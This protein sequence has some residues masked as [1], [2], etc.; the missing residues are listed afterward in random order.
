RLTFLIAEGLPLWEFFRIWDGGLILYGSFAGGA[1]GYFGAYYFVLSKHGVSTWKLIDV[2]PPRVALGICLGPVRFPLNRCCSGIVACA[3]CA[4]V[5][6]PPSA[7]AR[8]HLVALGY[9]TAAGF[10]LDSRED[11]PVHVGAVEPD[12]PAERG[13]LRRGDRIVEVDGQPVENDAELSS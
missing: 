7:P 2:I 9:Q 4:A 5:H 3:H 12:S 13:G 10:T 1:L 8:Y 11:K 6:Y